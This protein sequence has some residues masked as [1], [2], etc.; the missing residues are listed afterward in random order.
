MHDRISTKNEHLLGHLKLFIT[1]NSN[2][3]IITID[4]VSSAV[5][6][7]VTICLFK[8][9]LDYTGRTVSVFLFIVS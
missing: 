3:E 9:T 8:F 5:K 7:L 1:R 6:I 4:R 2:A